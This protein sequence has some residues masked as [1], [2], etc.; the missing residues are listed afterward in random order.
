MELS[1]GNPGLRG[2]VWRKGAW[3]LGSPAHEQAA[4]KKRKPFSEHITVSGKKLATK[5]KPNKNKTITHD[6][7]IV[8]ITIIIIYLM[9]TMCQACII[10]K[11]H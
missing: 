3:A 6:I 5:T 9:L 2:G 7:L 11:Y 1:G 10:A 8:Q 4:K